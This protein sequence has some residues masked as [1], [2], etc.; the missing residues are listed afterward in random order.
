[1]TDNTLFAQVIDHANRANPYPLYARLRETPVARQENGIYVV[2]THEDI[3][4]LLFDPRLSSD[5]QPK[6]KHAKTGNPIKDWIIN[7]IKARIIEKHRSF[8]FRDILRRVAMLQFTQ[9]RM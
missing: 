5:V 9:Q 4:S 2:S 8:I 1:M 6:P 7:P 3:R